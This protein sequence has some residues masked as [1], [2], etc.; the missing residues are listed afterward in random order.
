MAGFPEAAHAAKSTSDA[1]KH[2]ADRIKRILLFFGIKA[3]S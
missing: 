3:S 1:R 2:A